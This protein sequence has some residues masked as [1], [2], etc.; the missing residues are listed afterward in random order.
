MRDPFHLGLHF[1]NTLVP[2]VGWIVGIAVAFA[3]AAAHP[4]FDRANSLDVDESHLEALPESGGIVDE[5]NLVLDDSSI[6]PGTPA[7]ITGDSLDRSDF[8]ENTAPTS[9]FLKFGPI[10][11]F[12]VVYWLFFHSA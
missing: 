10:E 3:S 12:P 11:Q 2:T 9:N 5:G 1:I 4:Y 6:T 7:S 8:P